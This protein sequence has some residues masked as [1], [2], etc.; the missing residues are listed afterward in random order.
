MTRLLKKG[1]PVRWTWGAGH[2]SGTIDESFIRRVQRTIKGARIVRNATRDEPAYLVIQSDGGKALK[3][4]S[5]LE[6]FG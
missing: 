3:S 2:A 1:A 4:H 6:A 5:E